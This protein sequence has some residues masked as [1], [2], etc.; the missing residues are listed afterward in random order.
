M[1]NEQRL[2]I[3]RHNGA[4]ER[5]HRKKHLPPKCEDRSSDSTAPM[6]NLGGHGDLQS[7][8]VKSL[9]RARWLP[10]LEKLVSC[11]FKYR[12]TDGDA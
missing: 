7:Q 6:Q 9:S 5:A 1:Q 8:E 3:K 2:R 4:W 12:V 10:T 11:G